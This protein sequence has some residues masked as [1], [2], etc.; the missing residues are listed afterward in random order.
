[1]RS[2]SVPRSRRQ[3]SRATRGLPPAQLWS[4]GACVV[5]VALFVTY[6]ALRLG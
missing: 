3:S 6:A 4:L 1:M 5:L 2:G